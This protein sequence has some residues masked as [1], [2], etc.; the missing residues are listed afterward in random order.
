M[1]ETFSSRK[2]V[3]NSYKDLKNSLENF[4]D[5]FERIEGVNDIFDNIQNHFTNVL[6][7]KI[8]VAQKELNSSLQ[9]TVW[10]NLVIAFFGET[11]AG[12]STIIETFRILFD[13]KREKEDGLIVGDGRHD[14]T[15]EYHEYKLSIEGNPFTLIDVPGIE[16]NE[17]EFKEGIKKA[18]RKA[19]CVFYVQ[20]HNKKP[21]TATA[22]KIKQYLGDWVKVYSI[23]NVRGG[24]TNYDEIE[25][26]ETLFTPSVKKT[27][28]LIREEFHKILGDIY[29]G[30]ITI[31]A[32]LAMCARAEFSST[33]EDLSKVQRKILNYF[34]SPEEILR[35]S[36]FQ[37]IINIVNEKSQNFTSEI[38]EANKQKMISL[39]NSVISDLDRVL[40]EEA[41]N[42]QKL[43]ERLRSFRNDAAGIIGT[44]KNNIK[45]KTKNQVGSSLKSLKDSIYKII[46]DESI[47]DKKSS[48]KK[49]Q[50]VIKN[51]LPV[52]IST[53]IRKEIDIAKRK[54]IEKK[55]ELDGITAIDFKIPYFGGINYV[56]I[57]FDGAIEELELSF[58]DV[59]S[60]GAKTAGTAA[61]GAAVGSVVPGVGTAVGAGIGAV[62]G[63]IAHALTSDDGKSDAKNQVAKAIEQEED[64]IL[65]KLSYY[66]QEL[67]R[68]M[69]R[70]LNSVK[71]SINKELNNIERLENIINNTKMHLHEYT[72]QL[73]HTNYGTI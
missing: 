13:E 72:N 7:E 4:S 42:M 44:A 70:H 27:E 38:V 34:G 23:Y 66:M 26:R 16:G 65:G 11:N 39:S 33:R 71:S 68:D 2:R 28:N 55:K 22:S 45:N 61:A 8:A 25:E 60:W 24:A 35:F 51:Q 56:N 9:E 31:Q 30:N 62:I 14:Y 17:K 12:K 58:E 54:L 49:Q 10:D 53:I 15:K 57:D 64:R 36:Q 19:H 5:S 63:G 47:K 48:V 40:N 29:S 43:K 1:K 52:Q 18:L 37:T 20:G 21:D 50:Q 69:E 73:K 6:Y 3:E 67:C 59:L 41:Q 46:D 32:L